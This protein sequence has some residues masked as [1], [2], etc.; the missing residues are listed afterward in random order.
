M[1]KFLIIVISAFC[2]F[3]VNCGE[4]S[5]PTEPTEPAGPETSTVNDIDGNVYETVKIGNQ[6]W[7][8]ENLKVTHYRNG[9]E[10]PHVT[11]NNEWIGLSTG[12]YSNY[13]NSE[14][15]V[16]YGRLYNWYAVNDSSNIAP[17]GWHVPSDDD[18]KQ[19][20][21]FLGMSQIQADAA[22]SWSARGTNEGGKLKERG[23]ALW[24]SPNEGATNTSGFSALP[25]GYRDSGTGVF[26]LIG[27]WAI[28]WTSTQSIQSG[29][30]RA[31]HRLLSN[32]KSTVF[33]AHVYKEAGFAVRCVKDN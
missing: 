7:M 33:R 32:T 2:L 23:T 25:L 16:K 31:W 20:E 8:A 12:A 19:L 24:Q 1:K 3:F 29:S 5:K 22:D 14:E 10:I 21:M 15:Y 9:N 27:M 26:Y 18:W 30:P 13:D 17:E 6:W 11:D 4:D 28:F